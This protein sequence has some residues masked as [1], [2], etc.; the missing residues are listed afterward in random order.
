MPVR[1]VSRLLAPVARALDAAAAVGF[2]HGALHPRDILV[3]PSTGDV[4]VT[5]VGVALL[6]EAL[7]LRRRS[8]ARTRRP[9]APRAALGRQSRRVLARRDRARAPDRPPTWRERRAGRQ[10]WRRRD[11]RAARPVASRACRRAGGGSGGEIRHRHR[12]QRSARSRGRRW[13]CRAASAGRGTRA[14]HEPI[15]YFRRSRRRPSSRPLSRWSPWWPSQRPTRRVRQLAPRT[16]P[17]SSRNRRRRETGR[18][19]LT[20]LAVTA[21]GLVLGVA[22][23]LGVGVRRL[24]PSAPTI[25]RTVPDAP[26]YTEVPVPAATTTEAAATTPAPEPHPLQRQPRAWPRCQG[27]SPFDRLRRARWSPQRQSLRRH[28]G[29]RPR[30]QPRHL[31][32]AGGAART[33]AVRRARRPHVRDA[34]ADARGGAAEGD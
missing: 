25:A 26:G 19:I 10:L 34:G 11:A 13:P 23:G 21:A 6:F 2:R 27:V 3:A 29:R 31:R 1:R 7:G 18:R 33:S 16:H 12:V 17:C 32:G 9:S 30:P 22:L 4:R 14:R 15:P 5:G 20:G 28:A 24:Q 8:G